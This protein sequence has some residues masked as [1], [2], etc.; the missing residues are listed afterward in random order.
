VN[1]I[2]RQPSLELDSDLQ[3]NVFGAPSRFSAAIYRR[4]PRLQAQGG[5]P[6]PLAEG[7][8]VT[9]G[10]HL[11]ATS[12]YPHRDGGSPFEILGLRHMEVDRAPSRL[13]SIPPT[14]CA[15]DLVGVR[16][17]APQTPNPL[18]SHL[19]EA[20]LGTHPNCRPQA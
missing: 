18:A 13:S 14:A 15:N 2:S 6:G 20:P 3:A 19:L 16:A 1:A 5:D 7:V 10:P 12:P 17:P 8:L 4:G 9:P 11:L